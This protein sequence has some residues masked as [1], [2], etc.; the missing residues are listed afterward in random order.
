MGKFAQ[1]SKSTCLRKHA[2]LATKLIDL[3]Q[4]YVYV[5]DADLK[6]YFDTIPKDSLMQLIKEH[7]SDSQ[8]ARSP[9][10]YGH[11]PLVGRAGR[12]N[13]ASTEDEDR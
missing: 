9:S 3:K 1:H 2:C 5:V 7:I 4:G 6:G 11:D 8:R 13:L 10:G 12:F